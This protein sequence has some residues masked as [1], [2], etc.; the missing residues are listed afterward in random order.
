MN[1]RTSSMRMTG[2]LKYSTAFHSVQLSGVMANSVCS[3]HS[4]FQA[5]IVIDEELT[6]KNGIYKIAK[7]SAMLN[8]M[9]ATRNGLRHTGSLSRLSFSDSE[10]IALNI[11]TVTRIESEIV[12]ARFAN[13]FVNISHPISG[14]RVEH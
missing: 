13:E 14:K 12:E 6:V 11:S 7:C 4:Q 10:F 8:V 1:L 5:P 9:A 3:R 2:K